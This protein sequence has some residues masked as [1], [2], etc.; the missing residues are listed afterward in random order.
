MA[1]V[2]LIMR[3]WILLMRTFTGIQCYI[4]ADDVLLVA[5]GRQ[6][7]GNFTKALNAT[8][9]YLNR[10]GARVAPD[11]SHNFPSHPKAKA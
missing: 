8:H 6:M 2:A 7:V 10:M 11:K 4:L 9:V 3:P 5:T 1:M